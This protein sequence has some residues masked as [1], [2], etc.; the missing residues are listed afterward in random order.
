[1]ASM[2]FLAGTYLTDYYTHPNFKHTLWFGYNIT[3]G[4]ILGSYFYQQNWL[5]LIDALYLIG[6]AMTF[7]AAAT[8]YN[9]ENN[10]GI[11]LT[12][13]CCSL[14]GILYGLG[15]LRL[16]RWGNRLEDRR[17]Y[18]IVATVLGTLMPWSIYRSVNVQD[19]YTTENYNPINASL[20]YSW[21]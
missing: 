20:S 11:V 3:I 15:V 6:N 21:K 8:Y 19:E 10:E 17:L 12:A 9:Q 14:F 13:L 5:L 18:I 2:V 7:Y 1:M 4:F 16:F